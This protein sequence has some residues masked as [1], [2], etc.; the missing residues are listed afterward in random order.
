MLQCLVFA[1]LLFPDFPPLVSVFKFEINDKTF[2]S[3]LEAHFVFS[4]NI[5]LSMKTRVF[6][7]DPAYSILYT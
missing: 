7:R 6:K 4:C 1:L 3:K 5:T 2:F